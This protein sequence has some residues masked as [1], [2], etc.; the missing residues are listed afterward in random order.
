MRSI[1][2]GACIFVAAPVQGYADGLQ[3]S[4]FGHPLD[5]T[6]VKIE[7]RLETNR[8][9]ASLNIYKVAGA[10]WTPTFLSNVVALGEFSDPKRIL[11]ELKPA[12]NGRDVMV[13]DDSPR[14]T[15]R[16]IVANPS[17]GRVYLVQEGVKA[18]PRQ[19]AIGVPTTEQVL[20]SALKALSNFGIVRA[21]LR[22][23]PDSDEIFALN[24]L[25]TH[26]T[27]DKTNGQTIKRVIARGMFLFRQADGIGI[28]G[29]G[30]CG[31]LHVNYGNHGRIAELE[32][33]WRNFHSPRR[34]R[35]AGTNQITKWIRA[36]RAVI[37]TDVNPSAISSLTITNAT[38]LYLGHNGSVPQ[39]VMY[40]LVNL[41]AIAD[42]DGKKINVSVNAPII[43]D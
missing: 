8:I 5:G 18:L 11:A 25:T 32:F 17:S 2:L 7:W 22:R 33:V 21:E 24:D 19:V 38:V 40:P 15:R 31:G 1:T 20:A 34:E 26:T 42:I 43:A 9:P 23:R 37:E 27:R 10:R 36:G 6:N 14:E 28:A 3:L 16:T 12:L 4:D 41:G 30:V 35:T 39:R 29:R 13:M